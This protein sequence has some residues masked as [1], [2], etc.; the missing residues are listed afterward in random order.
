M[1]YEDQLNQL[2]A[3]QGRKLA[4]SGSVTT[5]I[6]TGYGYELADEI[7]QTMDQSAR[8]AALEHLVF[9]KLSGAVLEDALLE[10][11]SEEGYE[12]VRKMTSILYNAIVGQDRQ[13]AL[14]NLVVSAVIRRAK[15][16]IATA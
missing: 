15:T 13:M 10:T 7:M 5:A 16:L 8:M 11:D 4:E 6:S 3:D 14:T 1:N 9:E 2:I 12:V